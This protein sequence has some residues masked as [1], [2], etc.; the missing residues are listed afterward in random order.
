MTSTS[1]DA[2]FEDKKRVIKETLTSDIDLRISLLK[3][4]CQDATVFTNNYNT[5]FL[6][7]LARFNASITNFFVNPASGIVGKN[8]N[9]SFYG[10]NKQLYFV[11]DQYLG[12]ESQKLLAVAKAIF[13]A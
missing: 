8:V 3:R 10:L 9:L 12:V 2:A 11:R 7:I 6:T 13:T 1:I 5:L 4:L